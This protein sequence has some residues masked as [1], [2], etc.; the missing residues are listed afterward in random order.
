LTNTAQEQ[1]TQFLGDQK[2]M[3]AQRIEG[4][5]QALRQA[6]H[7]LSDRDE[8]ML[9][10]YT[11]SLAEQ[12]DRFSANLRDR[13]IGS[14]IDDAKQLAHRQPELFVAGALA[15]GF[16]LGRFFKSSQRTSRSGQGYSP[17]YDYQ[18]EEYGFYGSPNRSQ[19][20][21]SY[22][23]YRQQNQRSGE[24]SDQ[25][26]SVQEYGRAYGQEFG[27]AFGQ[28]EEQVDYDPTSK[29]A[30]GIDAPRPNRRP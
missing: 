19:Y 7:E 17:E 10:G 1:A 29:G 13:E 16:V 27:Q 20:G 2:G 5:A 25:Q 26:R 21:S 28:G 24:Y 22:D 11:D 3:A 9:A 6:G 15:A 18:G 8:G 30:N 23:P 12:L 4:V 14:L